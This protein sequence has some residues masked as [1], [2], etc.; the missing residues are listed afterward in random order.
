MILS[1]PQEGP[2]VPPAAW[3]SSRRSAPPRPGGAGGAVA[4]GGGALAWRSWRSACAGPSFR[5]NGGGEVARP[6]G[7]AQ[8]P[9]NT[10]RRTGHC[11]VQLTSCGR[12]LSASPRSPAALLASSQELLPQFSWIRDSALVTASISMVMTS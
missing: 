6:S 5:G 1:C 9:C 11:H 3:E 7:S 10:P 2:P 12:S 8:A 4:L